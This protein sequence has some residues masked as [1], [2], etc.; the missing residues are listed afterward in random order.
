MTSVTAS[1][2]DTMI[3]CEPGSS[4]MVAFARLA[5]DR[6]TSVPAALSPVLATAHDGSVFHAGTPDVADHRAAVGVPDQDHGSLG[7]TVRPDEGRRL[8]SDG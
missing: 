8:R 1:G 7:H 6:V 5:I 4:V 2:C 3:R